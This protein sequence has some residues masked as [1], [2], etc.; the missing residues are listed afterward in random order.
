MVPANVGT[1]ERHAAMH[2]WIQQPTSSAKEDVVRAEGGGSKGVENSVARAG[3]GIN[4]ID[5]MVRERCPGV[6]EAF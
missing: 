6:A 1:I 5:D 4:L 2:Y 3:S